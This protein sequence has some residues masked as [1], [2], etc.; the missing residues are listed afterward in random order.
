MSDAHQIRVVRRQEF[1]PRSQRLET[2]KE[3][4]LHR[5]VVDVVAAAAA[6]A[7]AAVAAAGGVVVAAPAVDGRATQADDDV[8]AAQALL[9][10]LEERHE[11]L[12]KQTTTTTWC[13]IW[14]KKVFTPLPFFFFSHLRSLGEL[15]RADVHVESA[16]P[17]DGV[18]RRQHLALPSG[19]VHGAGGDPGG[20]VDCADVLPEA[21]V[22]V[23]HAD[24]AG[25]AGV[26]AEPG[27]LLP[28]A[29]LDDVVPPVA[30]AVVIVAALGE[31]M[32]VAV[33]ERRCLS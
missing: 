24:D 8:L 7:A 31:E 17:Q 21:A 1:V 33:G 10:E 14:E 16:V 3:E 23:L 25:G 2:E 9:R 19:G 15:P 4:V 22:R 11:G 30:A 18:P 13:V 20:G 28:G 12:L 6:A 26:E 5:A 27:G 29:V 32:D